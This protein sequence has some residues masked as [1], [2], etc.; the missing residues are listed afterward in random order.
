MAAPILC[1]HCKHL[2]YIAKATVEASHRCAHPDAWSRVTGLP[3]M[4][5]ET[6][7]ADITRC[8]PIARWHQR[9]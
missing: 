8:G 1:L 9:L 2:T 3:G 7:R 6:V 5:C 4:A